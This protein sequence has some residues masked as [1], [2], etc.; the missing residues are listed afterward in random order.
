M[1]IGSNTVNYI[2]FG[3]GKKTLIILPGL[4]DGLS[5]MEIQAIAFAFRYKQFAKDYKVYVFSVKLQKNIPQGIW[6]KTKQI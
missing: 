6:L 3:S 4:G 5:Y 1:M 2:E